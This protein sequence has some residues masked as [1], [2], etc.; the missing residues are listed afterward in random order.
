VFIIGVQHEYIIRRIKEKN[1]DSFDKEIIL[2]W[3]KL[4]TY[5]ALYNIPKF[6]HTKFIDE[7]VEAGLI[8]KKNQRHI[9][10]KK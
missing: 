5:L 10:I 4:R 9:V 2:D 3:G 6:L 7:L 8:K 1:Q